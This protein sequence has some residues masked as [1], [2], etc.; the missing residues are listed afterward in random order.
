MAKKY[1]EDTPE[2]ENELN[3][4]ESISQEWY[5]KQHELKE[6]LREKKENDED[7][8]YAVGKISGKA[9]TLEELQSMQNWDMI[10]ILIETATQELTKSEEAL[11]DILSSFPA[12]KRWYLDIEQ[13]ADPFYVDYNL[14]YTNTDLMMAL[15]Y[16]NEL[17]V[18]FR[19]TNEADLQNS[20]IITKTAE[21]DHRE[22]MGMDLVEY[23][24]MM[25]E[26]LWWVGVVIF[27][28]WNEIT[29]SPIPI[30]WSVEHYRPDPT[31]RWH[32]DNYAYHGFWG[33]MKKYE[34]EKS[35]NFFNLDELKDTDWKDDTTWANNDNWSWVNIT[36]DGANDK[37]PYYV[38]YNHFTTREDGK[39]CLITLANGGNTLIRYVELNYEMWWCPVFPISMKFWKPKKWYPLWIK[40]YD[41]TGRKQRALSLLLNL[42]VK[43]SVKNSLWNHIVAD[44]KAVKNIAQLKNLTEF[45]EVILVDTENWQKN[46]NNIISELQTS[47]VPQDNFSVS[48]LLSRLNAEE[49]SIWPNQLWQTGQGSQTAT[50]IRDNAA[51][52]NIRLSIMNRISMIFYKDFWRKW[53]MMYQY[54]FPTD[55]KK[56]IVISRSF[57]DKYMT[58]ERKYLN[59]SFDPHI[60]IIS[61]F[62]LEAQNRKNFA[63][64]VVL[65][66]YIEKLSVTKHVPLSVRLSMRKALRYMW[67]DEDEILDYIPESYEEMHAK[68]QLYLLNSWEKLDP[69]TDDNVDEYHE[70]YLHIFK[71]AKENVAT[72]MAV[73]DRLNM[74]RQRKQKEKLEEK[75]QLDN[76]IANNTQGNANTNGM[77]NQMTANM[78][79]QKNERADWLWWIQI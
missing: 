44:H 39:K 43:K 53:F 19:G 57:G 61:K 47:P 13:K 14:I 21:H 36:P 15:Q 49:T 30:V 48:D 33:K 6:K 64:H 12:L 22:E 79:G 37:N 38:V 69:L 51:N 41:V 7:T 20:D 63:N 45:P 8:W 40:P 65:H 70:D 16:S 3:V 74:L 67:Y 55:W 27:D 31:G 50:E 42:A 46:V 2:M 18:I 1:M 9:Y 68:Q 29:N 23:E 25:D 59:F 73:M 4:E 26:Y 66:S 77:Q 76:Q 62:D 54:H 34:M 56:Q 75:I 32:A 71:Q 58:F 28:W 78:L 11:Q 24:L 5:D 60:K 17:K 35:G 52:A 10:N 72:R